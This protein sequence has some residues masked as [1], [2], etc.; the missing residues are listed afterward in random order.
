MK[1]YSLVPRSVGWNENIELP[2]YAKLMVTRK[3]LTFMFLRNRYK[4]K[5]EEEDSHFYQYSP[6]LRALQQMM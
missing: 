1:V 3:N 2:D 4:E 5:C 6:V